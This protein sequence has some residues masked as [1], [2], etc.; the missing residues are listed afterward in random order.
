MLSLAVNSETVKCLV[1]ERPTFR[2]NEFTQRRQPKPVS[3]FTWGGIR[4]R[5]RLREQL[6]L[7]FPIQDVNDIKALLLDPRIKANAS[8]VVSDL[9]ALSQ[10]ENELQLENEFIF[11][12]LFA[13]NVVN[14]ESKET[15][16]EEAQTEQH[17]K[18][19]TDSAVCSLLEVDVQKNNQKLKM[20]TM[21]WRFRQ[22]NLGISGKPSL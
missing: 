7:R 6:A 15:V 13:R 20:H 3:E 5:D 11:Q 4:C 12:K 14:D 8:I 22:L 19:T 18:T 2:G 21:A 1:L 10:A 9:S 17:C 16:L